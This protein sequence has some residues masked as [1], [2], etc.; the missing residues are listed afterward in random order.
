MDDH[1]VWA[2]LAAVLAVAELFTLELTATMLAVG[3]LGGL[4]AASLGAPVPA[5]VAVAAVVSALM[6]AGVRP[7]VRRHLGTPGLANDPGRALVGVEAVVVQEV[8]DGSGQ[9]RVHGELWTA[10]P[11][12]PGQVLPPG[13]PVWVGAVTGATVSV[14]P[15]RP[16]PQ[17]SESP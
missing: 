9:V 8:T 1:V 5:Q 12:L 13:S 6:L 11:A 17:S 14:H 4:L 15:A 10:R 16:L 2:V 3:A 7:V